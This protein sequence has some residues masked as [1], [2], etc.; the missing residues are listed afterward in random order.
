MGPWS[1]F[2][3]A[4]LTIFDFLDTVTT[5]F[6]LPIGGILLCIY[7]G[8]VAPRSFFSKQL[9]NDGELKSRALGLIHFIVK[10]IAPVLI[11]VVL[12]GQLM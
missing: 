3:I 12:A 9:T 4:G 10:W 1:G 2:K 5:N 11:A 7:M 8:W 6:M